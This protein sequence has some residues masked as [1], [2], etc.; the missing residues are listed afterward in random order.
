M[1]DNANEPA[2]PTEVFEVE[3]AGYHRYAGLTKRELFAAMAMQGLTGNTVLFEAGNIRKVMADCGLDVPQVAV[4]R[5]A[6][7]YADA[8]LAELEKQP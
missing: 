7:T 1:S 5:L 2:H 6:V 3:A 8:L 4:T